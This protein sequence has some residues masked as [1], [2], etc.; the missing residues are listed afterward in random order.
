M[1]PSLHF[2][3]SHFWQI[4]ASSIFN[5]SQAPSVCP[6]DVESFVKANWLIQSQDPVHPVK[7][8]WSPFAVLASTADWMEM[9]ER[10]P[11]RDHRSELWWS[12]AAG[13]AGHHCC[14]DRHPED[15]ALPIWQTCVSFRLI[16]HAR[17]KNTQTHL[18]P[19]PFYKDF[20]L[21]LILSTEN[22]F[23]ETKVS[24]SQY[25]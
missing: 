20:Q 9:E 16:C 2:T 11:R 14:W 21:L 12:R 1:Y 10:F 18:K 24:L 3:V 15:V 19:L 13:T 8:C 23:S 22:L 4:T 5:D 6:V 7:F 17:W 25:P